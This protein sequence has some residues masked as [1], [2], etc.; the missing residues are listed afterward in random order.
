MG[1]GQPTIV[2]IETDSTDSLLKTQQNVLWKQTDPF[3]YIS[4][5]NN[6]KKGRTSM[7]AIKTSSIIKMTY[8]YGYVKIKSGNQ[9]TDYIVPKTK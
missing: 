6:P 1:G 2:E 5:L 4:P 7:V 8:L 3:T 9:V